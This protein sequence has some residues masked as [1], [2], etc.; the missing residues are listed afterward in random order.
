M[1]EEY[2]QF[3]WEVTFI[4]QKSN[5]MTVIYYLLILISWF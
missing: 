1:T 5:I 4:A 2:K 3:C